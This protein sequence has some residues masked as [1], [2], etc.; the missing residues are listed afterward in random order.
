MINL[1]DLTK[2][3]KLRLIERGE[4]LKELA[5]D[6]STWIQIQAIKKR[7]ELIIE[8]R[9][10]RITE[11]IVDEPDLFEVI[12]IESKTEEEKIAM[13][14]EGKF[15]S[16]FAKDDSLSIRIRAKG[17]LKRQKEKRRYETLA[18]KDDEY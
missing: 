2:E 5:Q 8:E 13:I 17:A 10:A 6:K 15:L 14:M 12:V 4:N 11:K 1:R 9:D 16:Y 7:R 3:D 18:S